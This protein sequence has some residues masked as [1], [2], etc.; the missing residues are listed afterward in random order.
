MLKTFKLVKTNF[1]P[2]LMNEDDGGDVVV[3]CSMISDIVINCSI[4]SSNADN[5]FRVVNFLQISE[6]Q[7]DAVDR[8]NKE[9]NNLYLAD[10]NKINLIKNGSA[11]SYYTILFNCSTCIT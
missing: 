1:L 9:S 10:K 7:N 4:R 8:I 3:E 11:I 5:I 6:L 2:V